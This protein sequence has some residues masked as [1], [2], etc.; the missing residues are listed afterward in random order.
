MSFCID[1]YYL[2]VIYVAE[3]KVFSVS[4]VPDYAETG[5]YHKRVK[6]YATTIYTCGNYTNIRIYDLIAVLNQFTYKLTMNHYLDLV[7]IPDRYGKRLECGGSSIRYCNL[8]CVCANLGFGGSPGEY[9]G[10][11]ID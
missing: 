4:T 7:C 9:T 11:G 5:P 2:P 6:L 3:S 8:N 10:I 1:M